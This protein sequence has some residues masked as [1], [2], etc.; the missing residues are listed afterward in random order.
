MK[1]RLASCIAILGAL[2]VGAAAQAA[3]V[4]GAST[5][6]PDQE[7][8]NG[9]AHGRTYPEQRS[10]PR[11]KITAGNVEELGLAWSHDTK[12]R[13]ARGLEATPIVVAGILYT[14]GAWS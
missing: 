5:T 9:L 10:T 7:P 12:S 6:G 8:P 2:L 14:G 13:T 11:K 3:G 4:T 1:T